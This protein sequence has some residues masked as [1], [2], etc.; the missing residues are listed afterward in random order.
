[1]RVFLIDG[2]AVAYRAYYS[3]ATKGL[4]NSK[5]FP[6][7]AIYG[8]ALCLR[9]ILK[10]EAPDAIAVAFDVKGPTFRHEMYKEYKAHRKPTPDDLILQFPKIKEMVAA[11]NIPIFELSGFEADDILGTMTTELVSQGHQVVVVTSDKDAC[12]LVNDH[13]SLMDPGKDYAMIDV[14]GVKQKMGV[15][16]EQIC[17][18]FALI[19]D[20]SD[21]IPGAPGIG[22]KTALDLLDQ[23][24]SLEAIH[25]NIESMKSKSKQ[26]ALSENWD[27]V[28][29]SKRLATIITDVPIAIDLEAIRYRGA[30]TEELMNFFKEMEFRS[31]FKETVSANVP[32]EKDYRL[33]KTNDEWKKYFKQLQKIKRFAFDFETTGIDPQVAFPVGISFC[34]KDYEA[35][36]IL[37]DIHTSGESQLK[38]EDVLRDM[39]PLFEDPEIGKIG[40]NI[41]YEMNILRRFDIHL[42]GI[43]IDTMVAS[44]VINPSKSNHNMNDLAIEYLGEA[45]VSIETLIGKGKTQITMDQAD[46]EPLVQYGCQDSDIAWRL[47]GVLEERVKQAGCMELLQK[48]ELPLIEVLSEMESNGIEVDVKF[49]KSLSKRMEKDLALLTDQIHQSAGVEFNIKSPKQLA[50]ILFE[51]LNLPVIRKTK[52]GPS[53]DV[54]VLNE[55]SGLHELPDLILG[56]RELAKLKSTYVDTIPNLINPNTKRLHSS[57]NQTVTATGR[58]SSS[59][60]NLQNIPIRT[61]EGRKIRN[62]FV[63]PKGS[64]LLSADYSQIDL[65]VLAHLSGDEMLLQAFKEGADIHAYTAGLILGIEPKDVT[66]LMRSQAKAVNFGVIYGMSPFGLSKQLKISIDSAKDFIEAYFERYQNVK[67]FLEQTVEFARKNGYVETLFHR[68][69]YIP[70]IASKEVRVRQFAERT[71][72][73]APVQGTASD[74]IKIAM[75]NIHE[76]LKSNLLFTKLLLQVHDEL[77]FEVPLEELSQVA[78]IVKSKMEHTIE[79]DVPIEVNMKQGCNWLEMETLDMPNQKN[80][81]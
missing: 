61:E 51:K 30:S 20:A 11:W 43:S 53:T 64:A 34:I 4:E 80:K 7:N 10:D 59:D 66:P 69:R 33:I 27:K 22:P 79:L 16:P 65:R 8:F 25:N 14:A 56:Y 12:Q 44:Y 39:K 3:Y 38:A 47:A 36:F 70:E 26:K 57:F 21:N 6:T 28:I 19:G 1:M 54:D 49:L 46:V 67:V 24:G 68:R 42:V 55:L 73:N 71:A 77:V 37:F 50:E 81:V 60:P 48:M 78:G 45:T 2:N 13:V 62:A 18:L 17:D 63:A 9:K 40:Q 32:V 41:K 52:T 58:L 5:G 29:L 75:I 31:F 15:A 74:L 23:H 72:T 35:V 76:Y